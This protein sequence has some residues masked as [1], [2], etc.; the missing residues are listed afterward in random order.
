MNKIWNILLC[1]AEITLEVV[2]YI[3]ACYCIIVFTGTDIRAD[4][5]NVMID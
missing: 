5:P 2:L 3:G 4:A 1:F